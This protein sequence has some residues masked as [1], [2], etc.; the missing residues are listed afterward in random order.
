MCAHEKLA[1]WMNMLYSFCA[2]PGPAFAHR[3]GCDTKYELTRTLFQSDRPTKLHDH[4]VHVHIKHHSHPI[5]TPQN[6]S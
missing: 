2:S 3:T 4:Q 5:P 6:P 1:W